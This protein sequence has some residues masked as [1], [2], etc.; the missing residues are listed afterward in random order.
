MVT[1]AM[2]ALGRATGRRLRYAN[3]KRIDCD[4]NVPQTNRMSVF[5]TWI[6]AQVGSYIAVG[7]ATNMVITVVTHST[8]TA[9]VAS[10]QLRAYRP[11]NP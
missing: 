2:D 8:T 7:M 4:V 3:H 6:I 5:G 11:Y 10:T 1:Q 9:H